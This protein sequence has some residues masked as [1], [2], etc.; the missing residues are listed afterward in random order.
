MTMKGRRRGQPSEQDQALPFREG[1]DLVVPTTAT[2][3]TGSTWLATPVS[4]PATSRPGG[5]PKSHCRAGHP[6]D[7]ANTYVNPRGGRSC[8]ICQRESRRRWRARTAKS[9]T[10]EQRALR[11][12]MGAYR[13]H[14]THDPRET[15]KKARAAFA[16]RF[17]R[18]V[19]PDLVLDPAE[20]SRRAEAARRAYF[21][22]LALRSS[23]AR[24]RA[25]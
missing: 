18:E 5:G 15:T 11:S 9:L 7:E 16:S 24:R 13:L 8:R 23:R 6:Y 20:R 12:R 14:A 25:G 19:D 4:D 1:S 21:T 2:Q 10:P 17:E 22:D 3:R